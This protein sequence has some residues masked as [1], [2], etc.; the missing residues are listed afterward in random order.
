MVMLFDVKNNLTL[1]DIRLQQ[2]LLD[3]EATVRK[4]EK[5]ARSKELELG[6]ENVGGQRLLEQSGGQS[7]PEM[8]IICVRCGLKLHPLKTPGCESP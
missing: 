7:G 5:R 8:G 6:R 1:L 4:A 2:P 3:L